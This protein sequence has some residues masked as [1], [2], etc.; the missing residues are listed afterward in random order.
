MQTS[1]TGSTVALM[2]PARDASAEYAL[3]LHG[4]P[5]TA[6]GINSRLVF[7]YSTGVIPGRHIVQRGQ[8]SRGGGGNRGRRNEV[9]GGGGDD[10]GDS[11][12]QLE[13][14]R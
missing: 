12:Y 13:T 4:M 9:T 5:F 2:R 10:D 11:N 3:R 7:N 1:P 8:E 6:I 14:A